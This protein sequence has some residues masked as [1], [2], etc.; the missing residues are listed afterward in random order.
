MVDNDNLQWL[1]WFT[2]GKSMLT[3]HQYEEK[4]GYNGTITGMVL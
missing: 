3:Y 2:I 1:G 4:H